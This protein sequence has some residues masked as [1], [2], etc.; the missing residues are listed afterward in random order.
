MQNP[1]KKPTIFCF[2]CGAELVC[3]AMT[4]A[5]TCWCDRLP[6]VMPLNEAAGSCFCQDCLEKIIAE[7][8]KAGE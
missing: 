6:N 1:Q 3:G 5:V 7:K 2:Q 8:N 4:G